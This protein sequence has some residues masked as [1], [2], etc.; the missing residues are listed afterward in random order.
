[1]VVTYAISC[2]PTNEMIKACDDG[3]K[4]FQDLLVT[5]TRL[6]IGWKLV[7]LVWLLSRFYKRTVTEKSIEY[8]F[9]LLGQERK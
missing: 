6:T 5:T 1:M 4:G 3:A 9:Y 2:K 7:P 8:N